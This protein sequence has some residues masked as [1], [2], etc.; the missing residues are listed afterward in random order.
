MQGGSYSFT[1]KA[2]DN[3][4]ANTTSTPV[5]VTVNAVAQM[6]FIHPDHLNT[7]RLI[8]NQAAQ[9]VWRWDQTDPFGGN[10]PDENPSGVGVFSFNL[11][12]PGQYHD[13]E[14][15]LVYNYFRDY[16]PAIGRYIQS[17][18]IGLDGGLNTYAYVLGNPLSFS[19]VNGLEVRVFCRYVAG[20]ERTRQK[21]CFVYVSCPPEGW[22]RILSLF[23]A[24]PIPTTGRKSM[25]E[26]GLSTLID[27]PSSALNRNNVLITPSKVPGCDACEYE[28]DVLNRFLAFPSG[29]VFYSPLGPNSNTF[30]NY[31]VTS[32]AYG[33]SLPSGAITGAPGLN[34]P[35][36]PK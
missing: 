30:T 3:L 28:K 29:P 16:D 2:T 26:P 18:P 33:A 21:H 11:R 35:P 24:S 20:L 8:T 15:N 17:D 13:R 31:L 32:P 25:A 4:G 6:F 1:A 34:L 22:E 36:W 27:D 5:A 12:F 9:V 7:P 23:G 19:D 14:T 10:P